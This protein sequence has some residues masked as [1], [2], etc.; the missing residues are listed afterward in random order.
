MSTDMQESDAVTLA[1]ID[2]RT[3]HT[4]QAIKDLKLEIDDYVTK[5]EFQPVKLIVFGLAGLVMSGVFAAIIA[6]VVSARY[7]P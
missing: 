5:I 7:G 2:E 1:R 3:K 4:A 6:L